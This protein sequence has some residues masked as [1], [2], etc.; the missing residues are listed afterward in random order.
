MEPELTPKTTKAASVAPDDPTEKSL[1]D[2]A[3]ADGVGLAGARIL[4]VDDEEVIRMLLTDVLGDDGHHVES[5]PSGEDAVVRLK[6]YVC[7]IVITDLMMPGING[8]KVLQA[9]K[10]TNPDIEVVVMTGYATL[11]TAI[12]CMKLGAADYLHKPLNIDEIRITVTRLLEKKRLQAK[13]KERDFYK[14]L[15]RTD[16][17]TQL[18]NHKYFHQ[19][20][21]GELGRARR[22]G[23]SVALLMMDVDHFKI[24][25]DTNGHPM[26]DSAL[27]RFARILSDAVRD[28]D[29]VARYGGEEF[30]VISPQV[31]TVG[32]AELAE[33]LRDRV[34]RTQF[35]KE[36]VMPQGRLTVS[37]GHAVYPQDAE[38]KTGLIECADRA[39]YKAKEMG[40]NRVVGWSS[41]AVPASK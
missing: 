15:S 3:P 29:T 10:E 19:M 25:N 39:L 9:V 24:Y 27:Q 8:V 20:L 33:R 23:G 22:Y 32:A 4:V 26:G 40:R 5:V 16:G 1:I 31:D 34:D 14:E 2:K 11:D 17:L 21:A 30:T 12:E 28:S 7:D 35:E 6:D 36:D 41:M 38:D 18:F 37:V 13:A